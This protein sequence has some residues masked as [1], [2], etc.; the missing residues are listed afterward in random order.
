MSYGFAIKDS[1]G[2]STYQ[3]E[4]NTLHVLYTQTLTKAGS[5]IIKTVSLVNTYGWKVSYLGLGTTCF[6]D[7]RALTFIN[8]VNVV[9]NVGYD[10]GTGGGFWHSNPAWSYGDMGLATSYVLIWNSNASN[11]TNYRYIDVDN[12]CIIYE[13]GTV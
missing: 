1:A 9:T 3:A 7:V 12:K 5:S 2:K 6:V 13:K 4:A 8:G 11:A 10:Y